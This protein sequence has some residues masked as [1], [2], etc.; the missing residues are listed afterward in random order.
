MGGR[1]GQIGAG[2]TAP[3]ILERKI[4][5]AVRLEV[6]RSSQAETI[7]MTIYKNTRLKSTVELV[8]SRNLLSENS[9]LFAGNA[10]PPFCSTPIAIL[11][12]NLLL[13]PPPLI[14]SGN[15]RLTPAL[16]RNLTPNGSFGTPPDP[17]L[18]RR[19]STQ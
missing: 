8:C 2:L 11:S 10:F 7:F 19:H 9:P 18:S 14:I 12:D 15:N 1:E 6:N 16:Y 5:T 3:M 17:A 4:L 13:F